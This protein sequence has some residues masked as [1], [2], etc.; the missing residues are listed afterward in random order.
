MAVAAPPQLQLWAAVPLEE[1]GSAAAALGD[2]FRLQ[3]P[4]GLSSGSWS[5]ECDDTLEGW[6]GEV[7][8]EGEAG[9]AAEACGGRATVSCRD[10]AQVADD[11]A[12]PQAQGV[13][14]TILVGAHS[15]RYHS[16]Y[17]V[18]A[19]S[20]PGPRRQWVELEHRQLHSEIVDQD[21]AG[22]CC[23]LGCSVGCASG[24]SQDILGMVCCHRVPAPWPAVVAASS[25][26]GCS[27]ATALYLRNPRIQSYRVCSYCLHRI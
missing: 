23:E 11:T 3:G 17:L 16:S 20:A 10:Y 24:Y 15:T 27:L 4:D 7:E 2:D 12:R 14:H 18:L 9:L 26:P 22:H 13:R 25:S 1:D 19:I 8:V 21:M 5:E 6:I